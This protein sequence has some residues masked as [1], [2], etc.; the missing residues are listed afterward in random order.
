MSSILLHMNIQQLEYII[1]LDQHKSFS[2]AAAHSYITQATLSTMIKRLEEELGVVL[3]DRKTNP[4]ITTECGKEIVEEAKKALRH[5]QNIKQ[6]ALTIKNHIA[7]RLKVGIIPTISSSLFPKV[8]QPVLTKFPELELEVIERTTDNIIRQLRE[9]D[10]DI[11][12]LSTPINEEG[13]EENLLYYEKLLVYGDTG[14]DEQYLMPKDITRY[15]IWLLQQGHCL[16]DQFINLCS[17]ERKPSL[18]HFHYE[19]ASFDS[20]LNLVDSF[21]GLTL[22]PELYAQLL[23]PDK[24]AKVRAFQ[25]PYPVRE[26]S[27]VYY[28]PFAKLRLIDALTQEIKTL[29]TPHLGA[30]TAKKSELVI[31]RM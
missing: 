15:K 31:A 18:E 7:G 30:A 24:Q 17:L 11:G 12:I 21:G 5:T 9:G 29:I 16:R 22:I 3:F 2:K 25:S 19:A 26:V 27:L 6:L 14:S 1:A 8:I 13:L 20:L 23:P 10:L 4:I 28:R